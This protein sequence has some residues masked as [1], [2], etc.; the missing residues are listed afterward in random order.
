LLLAARRIGRREP[1]TDRWLFQDISLEIRPGERIALLGPSGSG[2][3]LILRALSLLDE[4]SAGTIEWRGR[5][6]GSPCVPNYRRKVIYLHQ[7]PA[8]LEGTVEDNLQQPFSFKVH[9]DRQYGQ[10]RVLELLDVVGRDKSFLCKNTSLLSGG[11]A[12]IT[13]LVRAMQ[14]DPNILLLDEAT[15]SL[16]EQTTDAVERLL[17]GWLRES[18]AR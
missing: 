4:I 8:F 13:A 16:D 9:G 2:K 3:S 1:N 5:P 6:A 14:L 11:E 17:N 7:Q 15:A 10:N 12:Q 18:K